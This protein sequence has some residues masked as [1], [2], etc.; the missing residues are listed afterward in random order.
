MSRVAANQDPF[1]A[2]ADPNRRR[3]LELMLAQERTVGFLAEELGIAQPSASQ[4]M[5][6]LRL[7]GLVD[8][9]TEGRRTFYS[10]RAAELRIVADWIAQYEAFWNE[11]LDALEDHLSQMKT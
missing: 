8:E 1:K 6:V 5:Q 11:R 10:L 4:H 2:I 7:A 3:M 9:R